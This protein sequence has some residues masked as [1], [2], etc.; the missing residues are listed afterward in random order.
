MTVMLLQIHSHFVQFIRTKIFPCWRENKVHK[1]EM[2]KL[3]EILK[4]EKV[5][6]K[7]KIVYNKK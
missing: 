1:N 6:K 3:K 7:N 2:K 5:E 4:M